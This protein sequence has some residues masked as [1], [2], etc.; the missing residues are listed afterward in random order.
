MDA[1]YQ[2]SFENKEYA[3]LKNEQIEFENFN[4]NQNI[5][6]DQTRASYQT[7][8][9][10]GYGQGKL[11]HFG[12]NI[13]FDLNPLTGQPKYT[14]GP[15]WPLFFCAWSSFVVVDFFLIRMMWN[16]TDNIIWF[17]LTLFLCS[18]HV[19]SYLYTALANPGIAH[20][21][22]EATKNIKKIENLSYQQIEQMTCKKCD[23]LKDQLTEHCDSCDVCVRGYDHHCPW[24]SK[25]IAKG[26]IKPFN[27]FIAMTFIYMTYAVVVTVVTL[28]PPNRR[29]MRQPS[30]NPDV[31]NNSTQHNF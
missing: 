22:D 13:L 2:K 4:Q 29:Y 3:E 7:A 15:H 25:C 17:I 16:N 20:K 24:S 27:V 9:S 14:L 23:I 8:D 31:Y 19:L 30:N 28:L 21:N 10:E 12:N 18:L 6:E 1:N 26:N 11:Q 5:S